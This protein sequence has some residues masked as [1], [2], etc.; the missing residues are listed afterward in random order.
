MKNILFLCS[1]NSCRSV[2]AE[3][4][5]NAASGGQ[6]Q[7][8]SASSTPVRAVHRV[9]LATLKE[10]GLPDAGYRSKSWNKFAGPDAPKMHQIVTV[11]DNADGE[12]CPVWPGHP[13]TAHWPF[14]DPAKYKGSEDAVWVHFRVVFAMIKKC[15]DGFLADGAAR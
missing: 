14:P 9:A 15:L 8:F 7:A 13:A 1:G 4:Y 11:C 3:A 6:W 5:M 12:A 2:L 10:L